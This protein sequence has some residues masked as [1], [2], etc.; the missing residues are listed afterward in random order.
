MGTFAV[1]QF[2]ISFFF[3][4]SRK[5][6]TEKM[7][8]FAFVRGNSVAHFNSFHFLVVRRINSARRRISE[9]VPR[10]FLGRN[11][12]FFH[13]PSTFSSSPF[14]L[15]LRRKFKPDKRG[16][17]TGRYTI[18]KYNLKEITGTKWFG[19]KSVRRNGENKIVAENVCLGKYFSV[20]ETYE[21]FFSVQTSVGGV[22]SSKAQEWSVKMHKMEIKWKL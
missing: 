19:L 21:D 14:H 6:Q 17:S 1:V 3:L 9:A 11:W 15:C 22:E 2:K 16:L 8:L 5:A 4:L 7:N 20:F 12:F 13:F 10:L 18:Q